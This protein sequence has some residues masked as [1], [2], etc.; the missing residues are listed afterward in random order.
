[1]D[2]YQKNV[3]GLHLAPDVKVFIVASAI[4]IRLIARAAIMP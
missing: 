2:G 1:M 4:T 3:H